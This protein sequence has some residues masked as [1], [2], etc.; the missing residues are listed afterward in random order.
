MIESWEEC[1]MFLTTQR[2]SVRVRTI[3]KKGWFSDVEIPEVHL[4]TCWSEISQYKIGVLL[5]IASRNSKPGRE[6][7][8]ET[9]IRNLRRKEKMIRQ[10]N[11]AGTF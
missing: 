7:P 1:V 11:N 9:Q 10:R 6:F 2:L 3:L 5:K 4:K 8:L